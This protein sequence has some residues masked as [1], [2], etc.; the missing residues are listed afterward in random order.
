M[1]TTSLSQTSFRSKLGCANREAELPR[2]CVPKPEL[3]N[4]ANSLV[5]LDTWRPW[6]CN[7]DYCS[8]CHWLA[9]AFEDGMS[10]VCHSPRHRW[11]SRSLSDRCH[12]W[13]VQQCVDRST[14][15]HG[16]TS[17][18]WQPAT[19]KSGELCMT[20]PE[21]Q[22]EQQIV[23]ILNELEAKKSKTMASAGIGFFAS[24]G[25]LTLAAVVM[26]QL[27]ELE[28][29]GGW[30]ILTVVGVIVLSLA[31][32]GQIYASSENRALEG[33]VLS[34]TSKF[35]QDWTQ[36]NTAD[37]VL[38]RMAKP[39]TVADRLRIELGIKT[40]DE[41]RRERNER[42]DARKLEEARNAFEV[43]SSFRC[44]V[45]GAAVNALQFGQILRCRKCSQRLQMPSFVACP[46]CAASD[47]RIVS[48][49]EQVKRSTE[50]KVAGTLMYGPAG[51]VAGAL[52][53]EVEDAVFGGIKKALKKPKLQCG[54]CGHSWAIKVPTPQ[55]THSRRPRFPVK[56][57]RDKTTTQDSPRKDKSLV[58][59]HDL[60]VSPLDAQE[61]AMLSSLRSQDYVAKLEIITALAHSRKLAA[62]PYLIW[63][64]SDPDSDTRLRV[65]EAL[66]RIGE[67]DY[68]EDQDAWRIWWREVQSLHGL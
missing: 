58:P 22:I 25:I 51:F 47:V 4:E 20:Q 35:G 11:F 39:G 32:F 6:R 59:H 54:A 63:M 40:V 10:S 44:G 61:R 38:T 64:L 68:G 30:A 55:M 34:Y 48:P 16:W 66:A 12:C 21:Q 52:R 19:T 26:F 3:G 43:T 67:V 8:I 24:G 2:I 60:D 29:E 28:F 13:L 42:Q 18:P 62:C 57:Q 27:S 46:V 7:D 14:Q 5:R 45:C 31:T 49:E 15:R 65:S 23:G 37:R 1:Q 17:Q 41:R 9:G 53:D 36:R 33:S 50:G 56:P